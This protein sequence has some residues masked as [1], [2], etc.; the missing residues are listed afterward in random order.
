VYRV[1][2][3]GN[4]GW[5]IKEGPGDVK[6]QTPGP[7]PI[8]Q[9][10]IA[11]NHSQAASVTGGMVYRGT[12]YPDLTGTYIFGDWITRKF[13][14]A[15]FDSE[16]V[17]DYR[18]IATGSVKPICFETDSEGELLIMDYSDVNQAS[19]IFRLIPNPM[20]ASASNEFPRLLS[21]TGL[22]ADTA[23]YVPAAGV[24]RYQLNAPMWADGATADYLLAIPGEDQAVFHDSPQ[25]M[26]DWFTTSVQLPRGSVLAKTYSLPQ[27]TTTGR[28]ETQIALKDE[29]GDWQYYTY[30]WNAAGSDAQLVGDA[31]EVATLDFSRSQIQLDPARS[32]AQDS[33]NE[34]SDKSH[35]SDRPHDTLD[36][37]FGSRTSC[38]ICHTPWTG[39]TVGFIEPQLRSPQTAVDSWQTLLASG[40]IRLGQTSE[41]QPD[42][43]VSTMVDPADATVPLD[44]RVRSYLHTNCAHC[45]MNGGNASTTI[46]IS[47]PKLLA[48][49]RMVDQPPMRGD[50]GLPLAQIVTPGFPSQSVLFARLAKS[51]AGRMP[52]IGSSRTDPLGVQIVRQWIAQLPRDSQVRD[53]VDELCALEQSNVNSDRRIA[54]VRSLLESY[55]GGVELAG[56]LAENRVPKQFVH[57]IVDLSHSASPEIG[58]LIEPYAS[59]DQRVPR[60]GSK[61]DSA[62]VLALTGD[63]QRGKELFARGSGTCASCHR[64]ETVGK[65]LGPD[66]SVL[67]RERCQPEVLLKSIMQPS[68]EIEDKYRVI[69]V[70]TDEGQVSTGRIVDRS[71]EQLIL[72]DAAGKLVHIDLANVEQEQT[73][74]VS[75]MPDQLLAPLTAQQAADLLAYLLSFPTEANSPK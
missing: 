75:M 16:R 42:S 37:Q 35:R 28:I 69:Q 13:W 43:L 6:P 44:Q 32:L 45:H 40:A 8:L 29:Q 72:Q 12:Q 66:L 26:F 30:R 15:R 31:G 60:L 25:R 51:G 27:A 21:E 62:Q 22:F 23:A 56:A 24:V 7:T 2:S 4:Y 71:V 57:E 52:H 5:A 68:L 38:R 54:A 53:S 73:M 48:E 19:G 9:A 39:E 58:D 63:P 17:L 61:F 50:L 33:K 65:E 36:W 20:P 1:K 3:G 46:D 11:L 18:E 70:L 49:T 67:A 64:L 41:K 74:S 55:A 10:D 47:Y 34:S 14:A 59:A